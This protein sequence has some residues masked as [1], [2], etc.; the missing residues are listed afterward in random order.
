MKWYAI[1]L[2]QQWGLLSAIFFI[3][4]A[5]GTMADS[6]H[7]VNILVGNRATGLGGAYTALADDPT[8]C[9]YNPAGTAMS[10]SESIS[11]SMNI[12]HFSD[13][14]YEGI[15]TNTSGRRLDWEQKSSILMP[16]FFGMIKT[17]GSGMLGL[18]YAVPDYIQ[19][20][21]KQTYHNIQTSDPTNPASQYIINISDM[22]RT[23]LFGPS[24]ARRLG[25]NLS[26]GAT[27]YLYL[28]DKEIIRNQVLRFE[29][30][31]HYWIN[32]YDTQQDW[33]YRP[34]LGFIWE[35]QEKVALG[36]TFSR[37]FLLSSDRSQQIIERDS[38]SPDSDT[39][40]LS[41]N[42]VD[43]DQKQDFPLTTTFGATYF[44]SSRL[45]LSA[46]CSYHTAVDDKVEVLNFALGSE[47]YL[48]DNLALRGGIYTDFANTPEISSSIAN[49]PENV[50]IYNMALSLTMFHRQSSITLGGT[51][52]MGRGKAQMIDGSTTIQD[53]EIQNYAFFLS[54]QYSF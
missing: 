44:V 14:T 43:S 37:I 27:L 24:Y 26:I 35:P 50:D 53:A 10:P 17:V 41:V 49:G 15:L 51:Y 25:D 2:K 46:D 42:V 23:Y 9:F 12:Y 19:R 6:Y 3:A 52:G 31:E 29:Q 54:A 8:G 32:Y 13:K 21:Q 7:Y 16:N 48:R 38:Q 45:L 34:M 18:S 40:T 33:G 28:R 4:T 20:R 47:Y 36:L 39:H 1:K 22:D 11:A 5:T 30:G